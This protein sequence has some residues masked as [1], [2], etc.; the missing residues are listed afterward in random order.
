MKSVKPEILMGLTLLSALPLASAEEPVPSVV[1]QLETVTVI[2]T[3]QKA[4]ELPSSF[5]VLDASTLD[6][7]RV[8]TTSEALRKVP[9][10]NVR[11]EEGFGLRPNI[12]IRGINPTR[13]TKVLL[14]EDGI[15]LSYA[16]YGDNAS[17]YHPPIDRF[18]GVEIVKGAGQVL[19]G[20]VTVGGVVNYVTPAPP[21]SPAGSLT[22]YGGNRDYFNGRL[23]WGGTFG[24]TGLLFD[25]MRKQGEGSRENLRHGLN[26]VNLKLVTTLGARQSLTLKGNY[27]SEDSNVTYSGLRED[28]YGANPR[29]N[30]FRNDYFYGDRHGASA[31]HSF[32]MN[33]RMMVTTNIYGSIFNRHWWRQSSNS[34]ERPNDAAN[35]ACGGMA[36]LNT[37]C[38]IQGRL[39]RYTTWGA[40]PQVRFSH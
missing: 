13:S 27:Y 32:V 26:D 20:P 24:N 37:T 15:P 14:L 5:M 21:L 1:A 12:G 34:N 28:E 2:G 35:P 6:A 30:P 11:D 33:D 36:N 25:V 23:N 18:E 29:Q 31:T 3:P 39:R 7:A 19:Y 17:Y 38:G 9:G 10:I 40:A 8:F 22:L 4:E 16:P